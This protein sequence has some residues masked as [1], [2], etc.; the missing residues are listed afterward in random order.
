MVVLGVAVMGIVSGLSSKIS[1]GIRH[2]ELKRTLAKERTKLELQAEL[3]ELVG[4]QAD[5]IQH[6]DHGSKD[7]MGGN[8]D[9][10]DEENL[11]VLD[12]GKLS[13]GEGF[14]DGVD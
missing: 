12:V 5:S 1:S 9:E 3:R 10:D 8:V 6:I 13:L 4:L 11:G 7:E 2:R 14:G